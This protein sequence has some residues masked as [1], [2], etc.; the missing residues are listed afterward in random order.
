MSKNTEFATAL[1]YLKNKTKA[2]IADTL[3]A[4]AKNEGIELTAD[5]WRRMRSAL[6]SSV[7]N[8]VNASHNAFRSLLK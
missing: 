2:D 3:A 6:E 1:A 7:E 4:A 5:G 8:S